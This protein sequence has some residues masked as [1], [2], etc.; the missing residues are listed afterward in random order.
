MGKHQLS[1]GSAGWKVSS[2]SCPERLLDD[3]KGDQ[4]RIAGDVAVAVEPGAG[5]FA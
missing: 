3:R 4:L 5:R 1:A 2:G